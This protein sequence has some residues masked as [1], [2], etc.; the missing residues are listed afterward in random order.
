[1]YVFMYVT[2]CIL[3]CKYVAYGIYVMYVICV[4]HVGNVRYERKFCM[5]VKLLD[6]CM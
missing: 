4:M 5:Y 3:C 6:G 2:L 1:M